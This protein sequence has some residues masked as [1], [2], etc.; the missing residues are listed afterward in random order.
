M[1]NNILSKLLS[2]DNSLQASVQLCIRQANNFKS[3]LSA[4]VSRD[5]LD[6]GFA[7]FQTACNELDDSRIGRTINGRGGRLDIEDIAAPPDDLV[8]RAARRDVQLQQSVGQ[9][10]YHLIRRSWALS[11]LSIGRRA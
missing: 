3:F 10:R 5:K 8:T 11:M 1:A 9:L 7:D 2:V 4:L 6:L